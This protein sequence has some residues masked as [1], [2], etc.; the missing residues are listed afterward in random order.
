[1]IK[2]FGDYD[3]F[4][5]YTE[6]N[7]AYLLYVN[8]RFL[9]PVIKSKDGFFLIGGGIEATENAATC[10]QRETMEEIGGQVGGLSLVC[11][12]RT[13]YST[14]FNDMHT[15]HNY[16]FYANSLNIY[17]NQH[18]NLGL[19]WLTF[20]DAI[21]QL[22]LEHQRWAL[23]YFRNHLKSLT[24]DRII[25]DSIDFIDGLVNSKKNVVKNV[26]KAD[27]HNHA[28][29]GGGQQDFQDL[30][31]VRVMP[32]ETQFSTFCE[33]S[34]WCDKQVSNRFRN[35]IGFLQRLE[36]TLI[37]GK[38]DNV[39][40]LCFNIAVCS[41]RF[42]S[43]C[44]DLID[45]IE[46]LRKKYYEGKRFLPELCLDRG[47]VHDRQYRSWFYDLLNSGYFV[48]LDLTG[49]ESI[50]I[51]ELIP[52]YAAAEKKGLLLKA[53]ISEYSDP[54][55][56]IETV[57]T[58]HLSQIQHGNMIAYNEEAMKWIYDNEIQLNLCPSSNY[59]LSRVD[60]IANHPIKK[61]YRSGIRVTVNSDD[62][63][64]FGRTVSDEFIELYK[65]GVLNAEE[66]NQIRITGL[67]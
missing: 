21:K 10:L 30:T 59:F 58:L 20:S 14:E 52:M 44:N 32:P 56:A 4:N 29:F 16:F 15:A 3:P 17:S 2:Q 48:S 43:S 46:L 27:L 63:L 7:A 61:L 40:K 41:M 36:S 6:R 23:Q 1:M 5:K 65:N 51:A 13:Y 12:T 54:V 28:V 9:V 38:A 31:G 22:T 37:T 50:P 42:F 11:E 45:S 60:S 35:K 19:Y 33:F 39:E 34:D 53:H 8:Y 64:I 26:P 55:L 24:T 57:K 66:L 25:L 18:E 49:D 67:E 62:I 47:K